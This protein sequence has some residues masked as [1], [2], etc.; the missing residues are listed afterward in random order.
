LAWNGLLMRVG[1]GTGKSTS[2]IDKSSSAVNRM[3]MELRGKF[4]KSLPIKTQIL[5]WLHHVSDVVGPPMPKTMV[6]RIKRA[7]YSYLWTSCR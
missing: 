2:G 6:W 3:H 7:P 5:K 4:L 1:N